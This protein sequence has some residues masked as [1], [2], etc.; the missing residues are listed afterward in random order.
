M[1]EPERPSLFW[2]DFGARWPEQVSIIAGHDNIE[3]EDPGKSLIVT[4]AEAKSQ[5]NVTG[6]C[7][8]CRP[9]GPRWG[10]GQ[11]NS[12]LSLDQEK[13]AHHG[14]DSWE[15]YDSNVCDTGRTLGF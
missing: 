6:R 2:Q 11:W 10:A 8:S 15:H 5:S 7:S 14:W 3:R 12:S 9:A 13:V 4:V 1:A